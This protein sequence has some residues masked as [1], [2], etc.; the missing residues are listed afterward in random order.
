MSD[1]VAASYIH[2]LRSRVRRTGESPLRDWRIVGGLGI[3]DSESRSNR[4]QPRFPFAVYCARPR[5]INHALTFFTGV[6]DIGDRPR[7]R[8]ASFDPIVF[9]SLSFFLS[10]I[11]ISLRFRACRT[12]SF[13]LHFGNR[14]NELRENYGK[15]FEFCVKCCYFFEVVELFIWIVLDSCLFILDRIVSFKI[16]VRM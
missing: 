15:L 13:R 4:G 10:R 5:F 6:R 11:H 3:V 2:L 9:F 12:F 7:V 16:L 1:T 8:R 14:M